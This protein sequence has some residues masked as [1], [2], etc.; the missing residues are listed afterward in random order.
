MA[1]QPCTVVRLSVEDLDRAASDPKL[2]QLTSKGWRVISAVTVQA[3]DQ[4]PELRVVMAPP[5]RPPFDLGR[6]IATGLGA[7]LG[8]ATADLLTWWLLP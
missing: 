7:G 4:P 5:V 3:K 8:V 2:T 1:D 6:L